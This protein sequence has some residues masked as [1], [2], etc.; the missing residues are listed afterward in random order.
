[1]RVVKR[2]YVLVSLSS[3]IDFQAKQLCQS[4]AVTVAATFEEILDNKMFF[5][6]S[7]LCKYCHSG[8]ISN[9]AVTK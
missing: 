1:M 7:N 6:K 4:L 8:Y 9:V 5:L 3:F 2:S